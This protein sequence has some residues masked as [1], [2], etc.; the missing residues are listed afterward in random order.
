MYIGGITWSL[1][2]NLLKHHKPQKIEKASNMAQ[3]M[4]SYWSATSLEEQMVYY[5][6]E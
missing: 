6:P 4:T 3:Q 5:A 2:W 1:K